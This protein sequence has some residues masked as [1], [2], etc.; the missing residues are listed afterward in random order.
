MINLFNISFN[1]WESREP[2]DLLCAA[3]EIYKS[4]KPEEMDVIE[5]QGITLHKEKM[6]SL[7]FESTIA[8]ELLLYS[9][10]LFKVGF[11]E[12]ATEIFSI[13][14]PFCSWKVFFFIQN[15]ISPLLK[16]CREN[17][18]LYFYLLQSCCL[19][20]ASRR[21]YLKF[22]KG[23]RMPLWQ[24]LLTELIWQKNYYLAEK[25]CDEGIKNNIQYATNGY[26][27]KKLQIKKLKEEIVE[28]IPINV[29]NGLESNKYLDSFFLKLKK[30]L[31]KNNLYEDLI[32]E[33]TTNLK[34]IV[35]YHNYILYCFQ[36]LSDGSPI[37][38]SFE[39]NSYFGIQVVLDSLTGRISELKDYLSKLHLL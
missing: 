11:W 27:K 2:E 33:E 35:K 13:L 17:E 6:C 8:D 24:N 9:Q 29:Y 12:R 37:F 7:P 30:V 34:F 26:E 4:L 25:V 10:V 38:I 3:N 22:L 19:A 20:F 14:L 31:I 36:I 28:N 32:I 15:N 1:L 23:A 16:K 18:D 21:T 39:D 5:N